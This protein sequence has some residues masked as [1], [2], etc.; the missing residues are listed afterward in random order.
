MTHADLPLPVRDGNLKVTFKNNVLDVRGQVLAK[1]V[2][3]DVV[4]QGDFRGEKAKTGITVDAVVPASEVVPYLPSMAM[5]TG[6]GR[7]R[8]EQ[9]MGKQDSIITLDAKD[10]GISLTTPTFLKP[11]GVPLTA[12]ITG[13]PAQR[14]FDVQGEKGSKAMGTLQNTPDGITRVRVDAFT[15]GSND[16]RAVIT[17]TQGH[18][19]IDATANIVDLKHFG[20][21]HP[22]GFEPPESK[23][24]AF[25]L[26]ELTLRAQSKVV[27]LVD[28]DLFGMMLD[29]QMHNDALERL[30]LSGQSK[31]GKPFQITL[32]PEGTSVAVTSE[33]TAFL[34]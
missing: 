4:F 12:T 9:P 27:H 14:T 7:L 18:L 13:T 22:E 3:A 31:A 25:D 16:L 34:T 10:M 26:P 20:T 6:A 2:P 24:D 23:V 30:S 32:N 33:D 8:L 1:T 28:H 19:T 5:M 15:L 21:G 11:K 17:D 29:T